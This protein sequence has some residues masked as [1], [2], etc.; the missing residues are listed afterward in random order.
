MKVKVSEFIAFPMLQQYLT[1]LHIMNGSVTVIYI[2]KPDITE[3]LLRTLHLNKWKK[4]VR[5]LT[6]IPNALALPDNATIKRQ[7]MQ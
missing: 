6:Y 3:M 4:I 5:K 1:V 7:G 2:Y